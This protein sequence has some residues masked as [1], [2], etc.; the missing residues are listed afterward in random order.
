LLFLYNSGAR[1]DEAAQLII[2]DLHLCSSYVRVLG[3]GR[4]ERQ[5]PLWPV[6]VQ[7]LTILIANRPSSDRVVLNRCGRPLTRFGIHALVERYACKI[8]T[9]MPSLTAQ[10]VG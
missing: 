8:K 9:T 2:R 1:A 6:T 5:C 3:K 7:K 4:E 10:R